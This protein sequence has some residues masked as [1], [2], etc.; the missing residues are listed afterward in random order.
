[1][2]SNPVSIYTDTKLPPRLLRKYQKRAY[3]DLLMLDHDTEESSITT[4]EKK[5]DQ[6]NIDC[7]N[8][9]TNKCNNDTTSETGSGSG[10]SLFY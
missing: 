9:V 7:N 3:T 5:I 4:N 10:N 6:L 8:N 1:M 2:D